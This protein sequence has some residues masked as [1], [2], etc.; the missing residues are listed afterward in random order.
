MEPFIDPGDQKG[1]DDRNV[2][3][4]VEKVVTPSCIVPRGIG[5]RPGRFPRRAQTEAS[6]C[7]GQQRRCHESHDFAVP[8]AGAKG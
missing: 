6:H 8:A 4:E 2:H 7:H 3:D 1:V 5:R